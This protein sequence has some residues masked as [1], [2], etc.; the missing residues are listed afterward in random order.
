MLSDAGLK[1]SMEIS[2][3]S[4]KA[5]AFFAYP[6]LLPSHGLG[7]SQFGHRHAFGFKLFGEVDRFGFTQKGSLDLERSIL[8]G[9]LP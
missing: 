9:D 2:L 6:H 8:G 4:I 5:I 1:E 3:P 7:F